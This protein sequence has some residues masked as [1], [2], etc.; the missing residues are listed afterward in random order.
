MVFD[1]VTPGELMGATWVRLGDLIPGDA[2][3]TLIVN[4]HT[5]AS[6]PSPSRLR[7]ADYVSSF[8]GSGWVF[9]TYAS[10]ALASSRFVRD[11]SALTPITGP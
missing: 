4:L 10:A 5:P 9:P 8:A 11:V 7:V 2:Q 1:V 3:P 6:C